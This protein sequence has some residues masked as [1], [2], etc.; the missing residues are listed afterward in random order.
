MPPSH[1]LENS[2]TGSPV[3]GDATVVPPAPFGAVSSLSS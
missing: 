3:I 2:L 1:S